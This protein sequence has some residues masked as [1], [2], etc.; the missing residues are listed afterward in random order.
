MSDKSRVQTYHVVAGISFDTLSDAE[1]FSAYLDRFLEKTPG[2]PD[3]QT[4]HEEEMQ[5]RVAAVAIIETLRLALTAQSALPLLKTAPQFKVWRA[6]YVE[7]IV[8]Q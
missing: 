8:T 2:I 3:A 7:G 5:E 1:N 4:P 6:A